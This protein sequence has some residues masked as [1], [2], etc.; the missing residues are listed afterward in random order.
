MNEILILSPCSLFLS[1]W[2]WLCS[3]LYFTNFYLFL[4]VLSW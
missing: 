2:H 3:F 1:S 4:L